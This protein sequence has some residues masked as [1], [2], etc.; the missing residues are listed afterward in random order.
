MSNLKQQRNLTIDCLKAFTIM[1]VIVGHFIQNSDVNFD[2]NLLFRV[3]YSVH[4]P[5]FIFLSGYVS[6]KVNIYD[7]GY[8]FKRMSSLLLPFISWGIVN[9]S[10]L[11]YQSHSFHPLAYFKF[12]IYPDNGLWFLWVL[13]FMHFSYFIVLKYF[14][15]Y[16]IYIFSIVTVLFIVLSAFV[17]MNLFAIKSFSFLLPFF[18]LGLLLKKHDV[19]VTKKFIISLPLFLLLAYFWQRTVDIHIGSMILHNKILILGYKYITAFTGIIS[20]YSIIVLLKLSFK[21][22][23]LVGQSTLGIYAIHYYYLDLFL[24]LFEF[25]QSL[26]LT[27]YYIVLFIVVLSVLVLSVYTTQFIK[28]SKFFSKVFLGVA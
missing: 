28:H 20:I 19:A 25:K 11:Q 9:Q 21:S 17:S 8:V 27:Y 22:L 5:L 14:A 7:W 12:I 24:K 15:K 2:G 23:I 18:I 10:I 3:I 16:Q 26:F 13:F 4:M 1:L 6:Y